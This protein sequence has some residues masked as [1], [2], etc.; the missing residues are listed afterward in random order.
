M[1]EKKTLKDKK[2]AAKGKAKVDIKKPTATKVV[3]AR[4]IR[5][6]D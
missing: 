2:P 3:S 1:I 5:N 4:S 6:S